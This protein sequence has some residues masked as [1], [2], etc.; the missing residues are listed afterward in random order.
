MKFQNSSSVSSNLNYL[1]PAEKICLLISYECFLEGNPKL[2]VARLDVIDETRL[3]LIQ[4]GFKPHFILAFRG[5]ATKQVDR[6]LAA[7]VAARINDMS[8]APGV[9]GFEQGCVAIALADPT[10]PR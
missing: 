3:S 2:L 10:K 9:D 1:I 4:Q 5:Q 8:K 7:K 6:A